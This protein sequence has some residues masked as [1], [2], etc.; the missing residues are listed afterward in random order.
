MYLDYKLSVEGTQDLRNVAG[1]CLLARIEHFAYR[2]L[3]DAK[4]VGE[5]D[6][7]QTTRSEGKHQSRLSRHVYGNGNVA[8]V[9][10][11]QTRRGEVLIASDASGNRFFERV[12]GLKKRF[13]FIRAGRETLRQVTK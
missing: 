3:V 5:S 13:V 11:S 2:F 9:G 6:A 7:R 8:L 1:G 10:L 12:T 4:P